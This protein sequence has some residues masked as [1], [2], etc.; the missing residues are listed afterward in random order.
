[1]LRFINLIPLDAWGHLGN[2]RSTQFLVLI[3]E[4]ITLFSE[5]EI[6]ML[7]SL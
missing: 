7:S 2:Y 4:D 1:V 3:T 6:D 5:I